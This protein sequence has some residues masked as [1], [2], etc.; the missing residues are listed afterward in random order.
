[1]Q[2]AVITSRQARTLRDGGGTELVHC[3]PGV[4]ELPRCC[5]YPGRS[6]RRPSHRSRPA[7]PSMPASP[8]LA[9]LR[10]PSRSSRLHALCLDN[11]RATSK[12]L[13]RSA[14]LK[15]IVTS[16]IRVAYGQKVRIGIFGRKD[17]LITGRVE[18]C[19][20]ISRSAQ[21]GLHTEQL[22][23]ARSGPQDLLTRRQGSWPRS[24]D[25]ER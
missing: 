15:T 10:S 2:S 9:R 23:P 4:L 19:L 13:D 21:D 24:R 5:A 11:L 6:N 1:M 8:V 17:S 14:D 7:P 3:R 20:P 16:I 22:A 18:R 12:G 25:L